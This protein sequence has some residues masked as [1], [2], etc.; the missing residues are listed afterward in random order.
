MKC[1]DL[2]RPTSIECCAL[3]PVARSFNIGPLTGREVKSTAELEYTGVFRDPPNI[4]RY[5]WEGDPKHPRIGSMTLLNMKIDF[6]PLPTINWPPSSRKAQFRV[7]EAQYT[8]YP[9]PRHSV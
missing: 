6:L 7:L 8:N 1:A 2:D 3:V 4:L 5:L 9:I